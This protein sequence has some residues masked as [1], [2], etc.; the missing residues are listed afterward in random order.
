MG[1][2]SLALML[3][4]FSLLGG[5]R[6]LA[7][8]PIDGTWV[9]AGL[10]YRGELMKPPNP[11]LHIVFDFFPD[12]TD[13]LF[14]W[15][16]S[17]TGFCERRGTFTAGA[18]SFTELITW[19]NPDNRAEC[20]RDPDMRPGRSTVNRYRMAEGRLEIEANL[21][22]DPIAYLWERGDGKSR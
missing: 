14:W 13:R 11:E 10:R 2:L 22:D 3:L 6:A 20:A 8:S 1:K 12:G 21:G 7:A 19:A 17:E 16:E 15:R 18:D 9:F 4:V 5:T